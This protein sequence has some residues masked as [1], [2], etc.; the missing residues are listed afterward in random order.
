[1]A[2]PR[3]VD[4]RQH[5]G[6]GGRK[7]GGGVETVPA[8]ACERVCSAPRSQFWRFDSGSHKMSRACDFTQSRREARVSRRVTK[9]LLLVSPR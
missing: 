3:S 5:G 7:N 8:G 2:T 4:C 9:S 1:M 6:G